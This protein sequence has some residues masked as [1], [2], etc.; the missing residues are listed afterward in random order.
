LQLPPNLALLFKTA[1]MNEGMGARLDPDFCLT[2]VVAPYTERLVLRQIA[3]WRLVRRL[4]QASLDAVRLGVD[5]P[6]QLR[7][8]L[9]VLEHGNLAISLHPEDFEPLMRQAERLANRVVLGILAAAF[10]VGLAMLLAVY[11]PPGW[12]QWAGAFFAVGFVMAAVLGAY[13]A[14]S[15]LRSNRRS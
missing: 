11:H 6:Q 5:M 3:P 8:I 9:G 4:S 1:I 12:D 14:W 7:R 15:I 10:I 2:T 13:L